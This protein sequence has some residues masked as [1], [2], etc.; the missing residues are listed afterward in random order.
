[1]LSI[2]ILGPGI[3]KYYINVHGQGNFDLFFMLI[4]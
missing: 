3:K 2:L 4:V 1:M